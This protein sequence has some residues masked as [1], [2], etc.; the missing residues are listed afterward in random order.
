MAINI[1][2]KWISSMKSG[3]W[4]ES[5]LH[6]SL[7]ALIAEIR[8]RGVEAVVEKGNVNPRTGEIS[9]NQCKINGVFVGFYSGFGASPWQVGPSRLCMTR[10]AVIAL[11]CEGKEPQETSASARDFKALAEMKEKAEAPKAA[12]AAKA[13]CTSPTTALLSGRLQKQRRTDASD[14]SS[15]WPR[16]ASYTVIGE[17]QPTL[18]G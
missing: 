3:G 6:D 9:R 12:K 1:S 11:I 17:R 8:G 14:S 7:I 5:S 16:L 15:N 18:T 4:T 10:A 2:S 13:A